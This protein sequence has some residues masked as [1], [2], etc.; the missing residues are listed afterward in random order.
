MNT[1]FVGE[2]Y[3]NFGMA[4]VIAAPIIFGVVIGIV[5]YILPKLKKTPVTVLL[6]VEMTLMFITIVE[7][8]FVDIFYNATFIIAIGL[9]LLLELVAE[10]S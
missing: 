7:G 3:A 9:A 1:I 6:Y 10:S 5:A 2:A 8:G 4:G